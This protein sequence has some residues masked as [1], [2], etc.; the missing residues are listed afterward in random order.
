MANVKAIA[1]IHNE[2]GMESIEGIVVTNMTQEDYIMHINRMRREMMR[3]QREYNNLLEI[4]K[5]L[6]RQR[7]R[8]LRDKFALIEEE[9][10]SSYLRK[11]F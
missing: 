3:M 11:L 9:L 1:M 6:E 4:T 10:Q 8:L 7:N 2:N 5:T